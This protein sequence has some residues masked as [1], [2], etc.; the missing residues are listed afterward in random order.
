MLDIFAKVI[1]L[2]IDNSAVC[3]IIKCVIYVY[4]QVAQIP[5]IMERTVLHL[6]IKT[7]WRVGVTSWMDP[8]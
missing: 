8:V 6:V 2:L 1:I 5:A 3:K 4:Q 7:V